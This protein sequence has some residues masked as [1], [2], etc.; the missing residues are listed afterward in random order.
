MMATAIAFQE[1][2]YIMSTGSDS[3]LRTYTIAIVDSILIQLVQN[4]QLFV[5]CGD[6]GCSIRSVTNVDVIEYMTY[7]V[8]DI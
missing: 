1:L 3:I 4:C 5:T 7:T 2:K 6:I 8:E